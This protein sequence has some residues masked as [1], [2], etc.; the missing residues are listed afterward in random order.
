MSMILSVIGREKCRIEYMLSKYREE[1][2][3]LPKGVIC[4]SKRGEKTYCYLKYRDGK[5]VVSVYL[6]K[7]RA[8]EVKGLVERREHIDV[9][10]RSLEAELAIANKALEASV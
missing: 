8:D 3:N 1:Y 10:I 2:S 4:E 7:D 6:S 5:K 9:M